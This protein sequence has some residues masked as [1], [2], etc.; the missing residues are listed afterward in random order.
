M[1]TNV[2]VT[3]G[4]LIYVFAVFVILNYAVAKGLSQDISRK[5][6]HM[7]AGSWLLFGLFLIC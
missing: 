6:V 2:I 7:A 5:M 4:I 1:I 3:A